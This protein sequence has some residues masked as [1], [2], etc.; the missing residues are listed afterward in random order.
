MGGWIEERKRR[1]TQRCTTDKAPFPLLPTQSFCK[2]DT[3]SERATVMKA[4]KK[5]Q[6]NYESSSPQVDEQDDVDDEDA[7]ST[8]VGVNELT[9]HPTNKN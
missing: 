4:I 1:N 6:V 8:G 7:E 2:A 5:L 9:P 3:P